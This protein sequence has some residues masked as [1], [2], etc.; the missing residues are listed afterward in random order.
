MGP[1]KAGSRVGPPLTKKNIS[2]RRHERF[3]WGFRVECPRSVSRLL[4]MCCCGTDSNTSVRRYSQ[5]TRE[6]TDENGQRAKRIQK[7]VFPW[8]FKK[9]ADHRISQCTLTAL[10]AKTC[11]GGASL[12]SKVQ[13]SSTETVQYV[14]SHQ[15]L[16]M[17]IGAVSQLD[18]LVVW[19]S[20]QSCQ[21]PNRFSELTPKREKE[22]PYWHV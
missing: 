6:G 1:F 14:R 21:H 8:N 5:K 9:T 18:G 20:D 12:L 2:A 4:N 17:E 19:Q 3:C 22:N 13:P 7:S 16:T 10:S 15:S 11:Q